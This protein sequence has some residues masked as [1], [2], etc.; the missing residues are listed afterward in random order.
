MLRFASLGSGSRGNAT[1]VQSDNTLLLIDCGFAARE[2]ERRSAGLGI[3]LTRLDA[4]LVTHEHGDHQRGVGP[5]ARRYQTPVW[6]SAG[7][8][9]TD[10]GQLPDCH[11]INPHLPAF[12]IGDITITPVIV[13]HDARETVQFIFTCAD[14]RLGLLTDLGHITP[15]IKAQ[16]TRLDALLLEANHDPQKLANGPYPPK[17]QTRV[18]GDYGHLN[19]QQAADLLSTLD[20][21]QLQH[22]VIAHLSEKNNDPA[23]AYDAFQ[24]AN[25]DI[26][27]KLSLLQQDTPS[28]WYTLGIAHN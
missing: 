7:T 19:N 10:F 16:Y 8:A 26:Q 24:I 15:H 22:L 1:L 23:L 3:D 28:A 12:N 5:V 2:L 9:Q 20:T 11:L 27:T 18:G 17:L 14:K 4:I 13:P 21:T 25:P 6:M